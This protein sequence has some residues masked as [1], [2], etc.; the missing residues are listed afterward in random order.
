M[1]T[2]ELKSLA[3]LS[4]QALEELV[5]WAVEALETFRYLGV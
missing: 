4:N 2:Y 1:G 5:I 3:Y